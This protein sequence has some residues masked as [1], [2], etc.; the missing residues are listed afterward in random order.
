MRTAD[1]KSHNMKN[2]V[3]GMG[4]IAILSFTVISCSKNASKS[5]SSKGSTTGTLSLS[6]AQVSKGQPLI[7]S[8]PSGVT[9]TAVK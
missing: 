1:N 6:Q 3:T 8:L 4:L 9:A 5:S 7:A 2:L